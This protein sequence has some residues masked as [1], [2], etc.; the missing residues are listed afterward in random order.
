MK[1]QRLRLYL[2]VVALVTVCAVQAACGATVTVASKTSTDTAGATSFCDGLDDHVQIQ[3]AINSVSASGG[4]DVRL[5]AGTFYPNAQINVASRVNLIGAGDGATIFSTPR[6]AVIRPL[7]NNILSGFTMTGSGA[8]RIFDSNVACTDITLRIRGGYTGSFYV[9]ANNKVVE[10]I[11][12]TDCHAIDCDN[13]GFLNSGEGTTKTI[14]NI[15]Y[16][17]CSAINCGLVSR[18]NTWVTGFDLAE[19]SDIDGMVVE[20]CRA[21]GNWESGFHFEATPT[22]RNAVLTNC[23]S[24]NNGQRYWTG[25]ETPDFGAGFFNCGEI[26]LFDCVSEGNYLGFRVRDG[27][28]ASRC[29][30]TGGV[31]GF[32]TNFGGPAHLYD[33]T[34]TNARTWALTTLGS[35]DV[36]ATNFRVTNPGN[37]YPAL[38]LSSPSYPST[39]VNVQLAST[40]DPT[41]TPTP[42][43]TVTETPTPTPTPTV[44]VTKT[45]T[46]TPTPTATLQTASIRFKSKPTGATI[47]I[48]GV[49][50]GVTPKTVKGI[51]LGSHDIKIWKSGGYRW[52]GTIEV[53][54]DYLETIQTLSVTLTQS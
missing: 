33:C 51:S 11:A 29:T 23:I 22:V 24:R 44:T 4:G 25:G 21:E 38:Q 45:P 7:G 31:V 10:N 37:P 17:D 50:K 40:T 19:L 36:Y 26:Q 30:D 43:T 34:S 32:S 39:N 48:D 9:Y 13:Y 1:Y 3:A 14:R 8:I 47:Y 52:L 54:P 28:Q 46:P 20:N 18:V 2:I 6:A 42:T 35:Y 12:F 27:A 15:R 49:A 16:T 53:T 41:P 5:L